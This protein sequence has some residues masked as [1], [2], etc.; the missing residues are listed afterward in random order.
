MTTG[1]W[2]EKDPEKRKANELTI[3]QNDNT[4][5]LGEI[6]RRVIEE[7]KGFCPDLET[8]LGYKPW[9]PEEVERVNAWIKIVLSGNDPKATI[10]VSVSTPET[11]KAVDEAKAENPTTTQAAPVEPEATDDLPF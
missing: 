2:K 11:E 1:V 3:K 6:Y 7:I 9:S 4:K 10:N 8:E 5:K